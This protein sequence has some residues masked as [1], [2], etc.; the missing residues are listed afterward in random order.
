MFRI[1]DCGSQFIKIVYYDSIICNGDVC[2]VK[3]TNKCPKDEER[4]YIGQFEDIRHGY[5]KTIEEMD[6]A[7]ETE[8]NKYDEKAYK[9]V[10]NEFY[11]AMINARQEL[12]DFRKQHCNCSDSSIIL[13]VDK[14]ELF[15]NV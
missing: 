4:S 12:A 9:K 2:T 5:K 1:I 10:E 15:K 8:E 6:L 11:S 14:K 13:K 3:Y 7:N